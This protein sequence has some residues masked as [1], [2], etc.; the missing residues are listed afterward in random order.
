MPLQTVLDM[1]SIRVQS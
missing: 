1:D